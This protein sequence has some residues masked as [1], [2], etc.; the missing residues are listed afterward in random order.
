MPIL[1]I[2]D[3]VLRYGAIEA[4]KGVSLN[5][6]PGKIVALLGAN[7]A[8]KSTLLQAISGLIRPV[9]GDILFE[10]QS[11]IR[12][13]AH[14]IV[15]LGIVQ[16]P[17]G[18]AVFQD[19]TVLENLEMGGYLQTAK[20]NRAT[21]E[22]VLYLFPRLKE[23]LSQLGG[24]LSGGE[25]QILVIGRA[26]MS[27][28]KVLLL[29]EPSLGIAPL[30]VKSIFKSI[31]QIQEKKGLSILLVE[32]NAKQALAVADEGYVLQTGEI[33]LQGSAQMLSQSEVVRQAYL[34]GAA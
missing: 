29:D 26:L 21:L 3:L 22:E 11:I 15:K 8:G 31:V 32:Q 34:G 24:T 12:E 1:E 6:A 17:E 5:L 23:R 9:S 30:L 4:V 18:R 10:G 27:K 14:D 20:Q 2:K 16:V 33:K 13:K 25:Q 28:P 19:L 7:G